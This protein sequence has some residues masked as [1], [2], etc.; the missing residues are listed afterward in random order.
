MPRSRSRGSDVA[1]RQIANPAP[2]Q[3]TAPTIQA[4]VAEPNSDASE[5]P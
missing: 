3:A 4:G 5:T 1:P 2:T